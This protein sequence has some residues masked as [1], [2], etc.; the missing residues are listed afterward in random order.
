MHDWWPMQCAAGQSCIGE[1][2]SAGELEMRETECNGCHRR[3]E[4]VP[5]SPAAKRAAVA[6]AAAG[7]LAVMEKSSDSSTQNT[8]A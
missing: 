5:G 3:T 2:A 1:R 4:R 7:A 8:P 6:R